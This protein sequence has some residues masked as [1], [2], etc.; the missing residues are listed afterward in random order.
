MDNLDAK[1]NLKLLNADEVAA[2][3]GCNTETVY[4]M[5]RAEKLPHIHLGS[6]VK[7]PLSQIEKWILGE[8]KS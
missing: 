8:T 3:L 6:R 4:R 1:N 7:F 5:A 2:I